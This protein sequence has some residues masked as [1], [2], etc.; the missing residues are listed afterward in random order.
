MYL[1]GWEGAKEECW[2][3]E[4]CGCTSGDGERSGRGMLGQ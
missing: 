2:D 4:D 1:R 3:S